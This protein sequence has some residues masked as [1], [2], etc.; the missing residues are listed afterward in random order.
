MWLRMTSTE[1]VGSTF[2]FDEV[3]VVCSE[4]VGWSSC[5]L[6]R[7]DNDDACTLSR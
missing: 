1:L 7:N 6:G 4:F 3:G 5:F 2:V